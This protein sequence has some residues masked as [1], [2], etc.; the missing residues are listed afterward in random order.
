MVATSEGSQEPE[1][2]F[3]VFGFQGHYFVGGFG[4]PVLNPTAKF[5]TIG[6]S[7]S[8]EG[9]IKG[10]REGLAQRGITLEERDIKE[11]KAMFSDDSPV[12]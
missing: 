11:Y 2:G 10:L 8:L 6:V 12:F 7:D 1:K 3:L 9:C 4:L 5:E